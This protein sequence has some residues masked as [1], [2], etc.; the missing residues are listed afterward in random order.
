MIGC[1]IVIYIL[2]LLV[3]TVIHISILTRI[4]KGPIDFLKLTFLPYVLY[5][6]KNLKD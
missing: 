2:Q 3:C 6:I 5:N 1:L 4:P